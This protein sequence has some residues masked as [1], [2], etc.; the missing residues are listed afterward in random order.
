MIRR[1]F[2]F[3]CI[4]VMLIC[5]ACGTSESESLY[6]FPVNRESLEEV[7]NVQHSAWVI[8]SMDTEANKSLYTLKNPDGITLGVSTQVYDGGNF[9]NVIWSLPSDL[10]ADKF[11]EFYN[12]ELTK[13][14]KLAGILYGNSNKITSGLSE[15]IK[16]YRVRNHEEVY[17]T[18]RVG[19]DHIKIEIKPWAS[20]QD[21]KNRLGTLIIT[22]SE[23]YEDYLKL[24]DEGWKKIA[25]TDNIEIVDSTVDEISDL[26]GNLSNEVH[27]YKHFNVTGH[28]ENIKTIINVPESLKNINSNF[29]KANKDKYL[30]AKLV[31]ETGAIDVFLQATSLNNKELGIERKHNVA[32]FFYENTPVIVVR[33]S[34]LL[35]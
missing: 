9:L 15:F 18:K 5:T 10:T 28:L 20:S 22:S 6:Q 24:Q 27:Y 17:W 16:Y 12:T 3:S 32:L 26:I 7:L 1:L 30:S 8:E 33:Y 29:I 34:I 25:E 4:F 19:N 35:D 23:T 2:I 11:D 21:M 13:I 14:F 31:D